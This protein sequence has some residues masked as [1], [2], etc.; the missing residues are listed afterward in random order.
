MKRPNARAAGRSVAS[1]RP[2][3]MGPARP[4][5]A[6]GYVQ[7]L[8]GRPAPLPR[9]TLLLDLPIA[10]RLAVG[11]VLAAL[12]AAAAAGVAGLQRAASLSRESAFYSQLLQTNTPP[13]P[14]NGF[15][16]SMNPK[17][18]EPLNDAPRPV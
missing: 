2:G 1:V 4:G 16:Q 15:L 11:F 18:P 14:G 9:R 13:P 3:E 5:A 12:I 10:W 7:P 17:I 8:R 6:A